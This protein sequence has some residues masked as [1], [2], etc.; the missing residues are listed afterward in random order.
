[1]KILPDEQLPVKLKYRFAP[2]LT[3]STE[4]DMKWLGMKD[5]ELFLKIKDEKFDLLI[6]NDQ[7][8]KYQIN[9]KQ[10][11]FS[12]LDLNYPSNRY[13]D[14]I[15]IVPAL[16]NVLII[17]SQSITISKNGKGIVFTFTNQHLQEF[18]HL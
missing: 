11:Y 17:L 18:M 10:L 2:S 7:N 13:E 1:M 5:H 14:L 4:R 9:R 16:N 8:L 12:L 15:F 6:T 3:V